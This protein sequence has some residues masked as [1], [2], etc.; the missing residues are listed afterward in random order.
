[1]EK[2]EIILAKIASILGKRRF[3]YMD[4]G[5][6]KDV[7]RCSG[8]GSYFDKYSE[9]LIPY[10]YN[11]YQGRTYENPNEQYDIFLGL[12]FI[13]SEL[14]Q[15]EKHQQIIELLKELTRAFN[16]RCIE[17][18]MEDEFKKL[19]N[20]YCLMGLDIE[21]DDEMIAIS[22]FMRSDEIRI[23]ELFSTEAWL[24]ER[25]PEVYDAYDSAITSYT[26]GQAGVCIESCRTAVVT[27]FSGY[28]GTESFAKWIRGA[29]NISGDG[30]SADTSELKNAL[31][32]EL[33]K[34]DLAEFFNENKEG[35]LTKTKAVYMIYS[36]MSDYGTHR[37]EASIEI[38]T[39]PD[40]LF[41]L[42]LTD[43]IVF[44]VFSMG[45]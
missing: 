11:H 44:W 16:I 20:L 28:K 3:I 31:D 23:K 17:E 13:F 25:H 10:S 15:E 43:S 30:D 34:K 18:D 41:M 27:L 26:N 6:M 24:C 12:D 5:M 35:K 38:P 33:K 40:A 2:K 9:Y 32:K 22:A 7:L 42:R 36:M 45:K 29:Y 1:M 21:L 39:L 19:K 14:Y 8:L 37:N 4:N